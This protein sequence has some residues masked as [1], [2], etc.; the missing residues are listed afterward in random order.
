MMSY[1]NRDFPKKALKSLKG[2]NPPNIK[3]S[4]L[5]MIP[6]IFKALSQVS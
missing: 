2:K 6:S 4:D 1:P 3:M 5:G